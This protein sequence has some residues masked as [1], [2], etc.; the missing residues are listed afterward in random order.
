MDWLEAA[1]FAEEYWEQCESDDCFLIDR[2]AKTSKYTLPPDFDNSTA[3]RM[4][5]P[6]TKWSPEEDQLLKSL[7][8]RRRCN[9]NFIQ[10]KFPEKTLAS[11]Q[12]RWANKLDPSI[13][14][15]RWTPEEDELIIR[16]YSEI[17]GNWKAIAAKLE[18]RPST[19][20]KNRYYGALKRRSFEHELPTLDTYVDEELLDSF[21]ADEDAHFDD[22]LKDLQLKQ[23]DQ[24]KV[25]DKSERITELYNRLHKVEG[26]LK[27]TQTQIRELEAMIEQRLNN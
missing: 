2:P 5:K 12:R 15:S 6:R 22:A 19:S 14:K 26:L 21:F 7:C 20:V 1:C 17:G 16:L 9:W 25:R 27:R 8:M 18:G 23:D 10:K 11:L 3:P 24:N 13:N 4:K